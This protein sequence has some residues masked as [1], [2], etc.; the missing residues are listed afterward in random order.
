MLLGNLSLLRA[1]NK[2]HISKLFLCLG[3]GGIRVMGNHPE[4]V[5]LDEMLVFLTLE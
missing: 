3:Y 1:N 4:C 5:F 2:Y